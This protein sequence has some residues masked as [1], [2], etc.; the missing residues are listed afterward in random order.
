MN[1]FIR[2]MKSCRKS[3][4]I[5]GI[6]V[7]L[8]VAGGMSKYGALSTSDQS[9]NEVVAQ[10]PK[11]IQT[12]FGIGAFDLTK[13]IGFFGILYLYL[14]L[15][16]AIHALMLG[17]NIIAKEERDKTSEFLLV[18]PISRNRIITSKIVAALVNIIVFNLITLIT[19]I[20]VVSHYNNGG[21]ETD[22]IVLFLMGMFILQL[23]FLFLGTGIAA[24][25]K[26]PKSAVSFGT[27]LLLGMFILSIMIDINGK[28]EYLKYLTPFKYFDAKNLLVNGTLDPVF[29]TVSVVMI[30]ILVGITYISFNKRDMN[31]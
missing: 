16:A 23:L 25:N 18:K 26:N 30:G 21:G 8:M 15:M 19:S 27:V 20:K 13:A 6:S 28:I 31:V 14:I 12:I 7:I 5:W 10:M 3:L 29:V 2:E 17:A 22:H 11:S 1:L 9:I 4:I 24:V